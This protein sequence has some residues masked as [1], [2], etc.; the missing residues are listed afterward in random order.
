[1]GRSRRWWLGALCVAALVRPVG[2]ADDDAGHV[3]RGPD[4]GRPRARRTGSSTR[5]SARSSGRSSATRSQSGRGSCARAGRRPPARRRRAGLRAPPPARR[6]SS[7][8]RRRRPRWRRCAHAPRRRRPDREGAARP[9]QGLPRAAA[10][11]REGVREGEASA[12]GDPRLRA[13]PWRWRP[14]GPTSRTRSSASSSAPDPSLADSAKAKDLLADVSERVDPQ[15]R[16]SSTRR[17]TTRAKLERENYVT[18]VGR[19]LRRPRALR[20]RRW[21]R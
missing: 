17:G 8:R 20:P 10:R 21:S 2:A 16:R 11:P 6:C 3:R 15:A 5:P 9:R 13:R 1:M 4:R 14:T 18:R 7:R 12:L 19:G